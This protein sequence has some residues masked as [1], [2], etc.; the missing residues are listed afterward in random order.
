LRISYNLNTILNLALA[1]QTA[2]K[3]PEV[4]ALFDRVRDA[5]ITKLNRDPP[6][7]L[8]TPNCVGAAYWKI[9]QLEKSGPLFEDL[10][11]R[12]ESKLGRQHLDT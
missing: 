4:I 3:L 6:S 2:G 10:L 8:H 1:H 9:K 5:A 11:K 12:S 7:T